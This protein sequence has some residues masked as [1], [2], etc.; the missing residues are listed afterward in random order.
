MNAETIYFPVSKSFLPPKSFLP[1]FRGCGDAHNF[2]FV[3]KTFYICGKEKWGKKLLGGKKLFR[4]LKSGFSAFSWTKIQSF[5]I[6]SRAHSQVLVT[7][8]KIGPTDENWRYPL[9]A[10]LTF[11]PLLFTQKTRTIDGIL[12]KNV[13]KKHVF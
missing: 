12:E 1:H 4:F 8:L 11:P 3:K 2:G 13:Q 9:N 10:L 6:K 5:S 7:S